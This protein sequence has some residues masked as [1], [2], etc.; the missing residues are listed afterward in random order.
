[1]RSTWRKFMMMVATLLALGVSTLPA[2]G[3]MG[4]GGM[5]YFVD[6]GAS[7]SATM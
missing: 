2:C 5:H 7:S 4:G 3:T 6:P 1:M